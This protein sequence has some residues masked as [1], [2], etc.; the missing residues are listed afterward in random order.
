ME[1]RDDTSKIEKNIISNNY[2]HLIK[3]DNTKKITC[4]EKNF[5]NFINSFTSNKVPLYSNYHYPNTVK[6][7]NNISFQ[8]TP[9]PSEKITYKNIY[10]NADLISETNNKKDSYINTEFNIEERNKFK[11]RKFLNVKNKTRNNYQSYNNLKNFFI[12]DDNNSFNNNKIHLIKSEKK[13]TNLKQNY[14]SNKPDLK[15]A[16]MPEKSNKIFDIL[17]ISEENNEKKKWKIN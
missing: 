7:K 3:K 10:N 11:E 14:I 15:T 5:I 8:N 6:L 16:K 12:K 9:I 1:N 17:K 13:I 4:K 2:F